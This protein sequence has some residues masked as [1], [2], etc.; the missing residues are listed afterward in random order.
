MKH[1]WSTRHK[2]GLVN[3]NMPDGPRR[4]LCPPESGCEKR[5][6]HVARW[7]DSEAYDMYED[8]CVAAGVEPVSKPVFVGE[9]PFYVKAQRWRSCLCQQHQTFSMQAE[10]RQRVTYPHPYAVILAVA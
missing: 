5:T 4:L 8:E 6:E 7:T 2:K 3:D 9:K 1:D 10:V